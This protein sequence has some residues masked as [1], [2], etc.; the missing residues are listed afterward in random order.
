MMGMLASVHALVQMTAGMSAATRETTAW[1]RV[2]KPQM[3]VMTVTAV[4][5]ASLMITPGATHW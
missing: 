4:M 3:T 2:L 1:W 5:A